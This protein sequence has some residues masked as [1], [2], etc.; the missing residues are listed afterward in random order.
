M[1]ERFRRDLQRYFMAESETGSPGAL[2]KLK[3]LAFAHGLQAVAVYR[4]G[5]WVNT[6]VKSR[7]LKLPLK[8]LYVALNE[9]MSSLFGIYIHGGADIG[10][11]LFIPHSHGIIIG[12]VEMGEDCMIGQ[13]VTL[14]V[15]PGVGP[16]CPRLG[17]R[18][19]VGP[20]AVIFG[21]IKI[22]DGAAIGPLTMVGRNVPPRSLVVGNP[23]QILKRNF[24]NSGLLYRGG[25]MPPSSPV[26]APVSAAPVSVEVEPEGPAA[27]ATATG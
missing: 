20:G 1:F 5:A 27:P 4:F 9:T 11:G 7:P 12:R 18:V 23:M 8:A 6:E 15:R 13:N 2:E 14:G 25:R 17:D 19:F 3:I 21:D 24:D 10:G 22:A 16:E 26:A